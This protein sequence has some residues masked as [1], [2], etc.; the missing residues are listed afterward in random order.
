[1]HLLAQLAVFS[2]ADLRRGEGEPM[3][4]RIALYSF[5]RAELKLYAHILETYLHAEVTACYDS[6][7]LRE[8]MPGQHCAVIVRMRNHRTQDGWTHL[9]N[10]PNVEDCFRAYCPGRFAVLLKHS[11]EIAEKK[12]GHLYG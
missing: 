6:F 10:A 12:K 1:L 8:S 5:D 3:K 4:T 11:R 9:R 2:A 7:T